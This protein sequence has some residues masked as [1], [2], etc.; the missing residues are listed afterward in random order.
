[1][2]TLVVLAVHLLLTAVSDSPSA[3]GDKLSMSESPTFK[4]CRL[5]HAQGQFHLLSD[6]L[7]GRVLSFSSGEDLLLSFEL[8]CK[9]FRL[10]SLRGTPWHDANVD[11]LRAL[12]S[13]DSVQVAAPWSFLCS[14]RLKF[15]TTLSV[16]L[17]SSD[18][19]WL[20]QSKLP[21]LRSLRLATSSFDELVLR[22]YAF[23]PL[24]HMT[25]ITVLPCFLV[26]GRARAVCRR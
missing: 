1:M 10:S 6:A 18:L 23:R 24:E 14:G 8:V 20:Q 11:S 22:S 15:V 17:R 13:P 25:S 5:L 16:V 19:F 9:R 12:E 2:F 26:G 7:L 4:R 3:A 21:R